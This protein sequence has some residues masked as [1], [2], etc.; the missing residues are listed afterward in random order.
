[1]SE[2]TVKCFPLAGAQDY[3]VEDF[4]NY[5]AMRTAGVYAAGDNLKVGESAVPA[6]TVRVLP[7]VAWLTVGTYAGV[8]FPIRYAQTLTIEAA[9][10]INERYDSII[11]GINK[12]TRSGYLKVQKGAWA[13][14]PPEPVRDETYFEIV[15]AHVHIPA[16]TAEIED[17]LITDK[18]TDAEVCGLINEGAQI[19]ND[20][21]TE[22]D[23][24]I[25][26]AQLGRI[27]E[28]TLDQ[29]PAAPAVSCWYFATD[30]E[31]FYFYSKIL[32]RWVEK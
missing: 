28:G 8:S 30:Y 32:G 11:A 4:Q 12:T 10:G 13:G 26:G 31:A 24:G 22:N 2:I 14:S 25:M 18:R 29:R 21:T 19:I 20:L 3:N 6:M 17:A 16:G 5:L 9:D 7:G 27:S 23:A 1:M 15:L